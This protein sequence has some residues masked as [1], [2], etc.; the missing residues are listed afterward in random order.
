MLPD[1]AKQHK[2]RVLLTG[3]SGFVG[4]YVL[5]ALRARNYAVRVL[6]RSPG[7][8]TSSDSGISDPGISD[9]GIE[10][11]PGDVTDPDSVRAAAVGCHAVVH[12]VGIIEEN[13]RAGITFERIHV[14]GT[15]NVVEAAR[16]AGIDTFVHM[17]ANRAAPD[18][19]TAYLTTKWR[20]EE[21]VRGAGFTHWTVFR[22]SII[23]GKP[24]SGQPEF[25]T[26]LLQTLVK[27]FPIW[28]VFGDGAYR[29]QPI[30]VEDVAEAFARAVSDPAFSGKSYCT[31]A[32][33]SFPYVEI[34]DMLALGAGMKPRPK[35]HVPIWM[36]KPVIELMAPLRVLPIT[37]EQLEMLIG[38]NTCDASDFL[39]DLALEPKPFTVE[40][41]SYLR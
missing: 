28:P 10:A 25:A 37:P 33:V 36:A 18:G 11:A 39:S 1:D 19:E 8:F 38:G 15:R 14:E 40:N 12:L 7:D 16:S 4:S 9:S 22:P 20:A 32:D 23:F 13:P 3:G 26:R 24:A 2:L 30:A 31:A 21:I 34:L 35:F 17:S 41:L 5:R 6:R 27:P 29:L